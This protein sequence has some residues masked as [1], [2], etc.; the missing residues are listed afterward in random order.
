MK[1]FK[2][3]GRSGVNTFVQRQN[4]QPSVRFIN[5]GSYRMFASEGQASVEDTVVSRCTQKITELLKP[6]KVVVTSTNSDPNGSHVRLHSS[7]FI[8]G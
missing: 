2:L 5:R 1:G 8:F 3:L 4:I 7:C 6:A